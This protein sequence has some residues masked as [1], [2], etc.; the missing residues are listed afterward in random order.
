[1]E[2]TGKRTHGTLRELAAV[3]SRP[4]VL[5]AMCLVLVLVGLLSA[6]VPTRRASRVD[7][8]IALRAE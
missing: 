4:L 1:M 7:T 8:I 6:L 2:G 3:L 5:G